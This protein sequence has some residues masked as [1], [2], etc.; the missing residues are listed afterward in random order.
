VPRL[1][2]INAYYPPDPLPTGKVLKEVVQFLEGKGW[3]VV[4]LTGGKNFPVDLKEKV[5]VVRL[6]VF[7][8]R[9]GLFFRIVHLLSFFF[10]GVVAIFRLRG[11][12]Y[13]SM[14]SPPLIPLYLSV[15]GKFLF[16]K[17]I[18]YWVQDLYP[19]LLTPFFPSSLRPLLSV[20]IPFLVFPERWVDRYWV[21]TEKMKETL[22]MRGVSEDRIEVIPNP[23]FSGKE[24]GDPL[25]DTKRNSPFLPWKGDGS[26][27]LF[28]GG[29]FGRVHE[30]DTLLGG[31]DLLV[32]E[33]V[34]LI[35]AGGGPRKEEVKKKVLPH[36]PVKVFG[37]YS[38]EEEVEFLKRVDVGIVTLR[39]GMD[40]YCIPHKIF[41]YMAYSLPILFV[42]EIHSYPASLIRTIGCGLVVGCGDKEGVREAVLSFLKMGVEGRR[43]MGERGYRYL[44]EN[45][46][47]EKA[48]L[49]YF[50]SLKEV[51]SLRESVSS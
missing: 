50:T 41:T 23:V 49:P 48:F 9:Q 13:L 26:L 6:P 5:R 38:E 25:R 7:P 15:L 31:I 1:I 27:L 44:E 22:Q 24:K 19:D 45:F 3:E 21:L 40:R 39:E 20:L 42:G 16:R 14:S 2:A 11:D 36:H 51:L 34:F 8:P 43:S 10:L 37:R 47:G 30:F 46:C 18:I 29:N 28:Y 12:G 32:G 17:P 4:I 35:L 33:K